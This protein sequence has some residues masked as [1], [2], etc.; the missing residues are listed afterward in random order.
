[1][2]IFS[3]SKGNAAEAFRH[4]R[5]GYKQWK[6]GCICSLFAKPNAKGKQLLFLVKAKAC[7]SMKSAQHTFHAHLDQ[8]NGNVVHAKCNC[9]TGQSGCCKQ[10][11]ALLHTLIDCVNMGT[12]DFLTDLT[13]T[14]VEK[15]WHVTSVAKNVPSRAIKFNTVAF[16]KVEKGR[17]KRI[18]FRELYCTTSHFALDIS[19]NELQSLVSIL[20]TL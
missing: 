5:Q 11:A 7:V 8:L 17:R 14:Q 2:L 18:K 15:T 10:V 13:S 6:E 3:S 16:E 19:S 9:K 1:M 12:Q 20:T 4:K